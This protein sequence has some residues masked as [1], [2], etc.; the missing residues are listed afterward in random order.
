MQVNFIYF[1]STASPS[2]SFEALVKT[3]ALGSP[4]PSCPRPPLHG[5]FPAPWI[6]LRHR[7]STKTKKSISWWRWVST[8]R[9]RNPGFLPERGFLVRI[10]PFS[11][12]STTSNINIEKPFKIFNKRETY[13]P[14][15]CLP[16][17]SPHWIWDIHLFFWQK[18]VRIG[19]PS[20]FPNDIFEGSS[21]T[22]GPGPAKTGWWLPVLG[23]FRG[24][25]APYEKTRTKKKKASSR[26][27]I[28]SMIWS[29]VM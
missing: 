21:C 2:D 27:F 16:T 11:R 1:S 29:Q 7:V 3:E 23:I 26:D 28:Y 14:N 9:K 15:C 22:P 12:C 25:T 17:P 8:K 10:I 5:T 20:H 6:H 13:F 18:F 19:W 24:L 4:I